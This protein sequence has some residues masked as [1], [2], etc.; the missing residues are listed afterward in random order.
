MLVRTPTQFYG[1]F[2]N[3]HMISYMLDGSSML[4]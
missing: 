3:M 1:A 2:K 4:C